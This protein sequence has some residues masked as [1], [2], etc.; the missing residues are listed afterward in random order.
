M[1]S[2]LKSLELVK[3]ISLIRK[4]ICFE[5]EKRLTKFIDSL[6]FIRNQKSSTYRKPLFLYFAQLRMKG[7][8]LQID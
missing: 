2:N 4:L 8:Q 6:F 7:L 5:Y 1:N 3:I